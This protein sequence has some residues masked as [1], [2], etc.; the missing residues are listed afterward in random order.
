MN[1]GYIVR[2]IQQ[3]PQFIEAVKELEGGSRR[4]NM[5]GLSGS[6]SAFWAAALAGKGFP[7]VMVCNSGA[8]AREVLE[9]LRSIAGRV[10]Y[11][12]PLQPILYND[13]VHSMEAEWERI[14]TLDALA[15]GGADM[16][17]APAEALFFPVMPS[18]RYK[19]TTLIIRTGEEPGMD[20]V[21]ERLVTA[22]YERGY[23]TEGPGQF[24]VRGGILDIFPVGSPSPCRIE[25]FGDMVDSIRILDADSQ[26]SVDKIDGIRVPPCRELLTEPEERERILRNMDVDLSKTVE[27]LNAFGLG[28]RAEELKEDTAAV[29]AAIATESGTRLLGNYWMYGC[30]TVSL[31]DY[32]DKNCLV[33][34][35]NPVRIKEEAE[36][37]HGDFIDHYND[38]REKG[39][40]LL[41]QQHR[42]LAPVQVEIMLDKIRV[43]GITDILKG[44]GITFG[45]STRGMESFHGKLPLA[46]KEIA[47]LRKDGYL[48]GVLVG[49]DSRLGTLREELVKNDIHPA[50]AEGSTD[51]EFPAGTVVLGRGTVKEGFLF[52]GA[53]LAV[54]SDGDIFGTAKKRFRAVPKAKKQGIEVFTELSPGDYVVHENQGI[55]IYKGIQELKV[56][57]I[58]RDYLKIEYRNGDMLYLPTYQSHLIQKYVGAEG[59]KVRV[60][61]M[62]GREWAKTKASVKRA[63]EGMARELLQLYAAREA[64]AGHAFGGD[65]VWQKQFD[66]LFPFEE[67]PDQIRCIE[68]TKRDMERRRPMDRLLCGDVGYGKTE[69]AMRAAFKAVMDGKQVAMLVPTTILAQQHYNTFRQRMEQFPINIEMM[70]RFRTAGQQQEIL[71]LLKEG[72]IDIL[73]GTHRLL[74]QDVVFKDLGLLVVDE[75]QRFG[76][77]HKEAIKRL[78]ENIDVLTLTAT[79]IPRTLHMSMAGIRDMSVILDPPRDRFPVETFIVE[80]SDR[81]IRDAIQREL[82]RNGQV[83]FVH[84]RVHSI[85]KMARELHALVPG[86]TIGIAHGQMDER[87]LERVMLDFLERRYD[88]L[89]CTTI[90]ENGLDMPNVNTIIVTDSDRLGLSQMYQLKGRVGRSNRIAYAYFTYRKDKV[91]T[92]AAEKRLKAIKE[93]TEFGSGFRIALRDLEIR[94]AGNILGPEQHGHMMAVG[95]DLY[96]KLL[97][98][99]VKE[100]KGLPVEQ[101]VEPQLD[102][103]VDAYISDSYI[104]DEKQKVEIYR[105]IASID[106]FDDYLDVYEELCDRFGEPAGPVTN[107]L[108]LSHIKSMCQRLG[109]QAVSQRDNAIKFEFTQKAPVEPRAL[110]AF[111]NEYAG[112]VKFKASG[113]PS[114]TFRVETG[115]PYK[116][117]LSIKGIIEK[118][119]C[120]NNG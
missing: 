63:I 107:L 119:I 117:L 70:S 75:E 35:D 50:L 103:E 96:C 44:Q 27:R 78:K 39:K 45:F 51:R 28:D 68:E 46:V 9:D 116:L 83:Y 5:S 30:E 62:G 89:L 16:M 77:R 38:R 32:L 85:E 57:N 66:D 19:K 88:I 23:M 37:F 104:P 84:N 8:R 87:A 120:F 31:F 21:L 95:Y 73:I 76:V 69:V 98:Q 118:I 29:K 74:Q 12:P 6:R 26:R 15:S 56:E 61:K 108:L 17:V 115:D 53:K 94:G 92:E 54:F 13:M 105:R 34:L 24:S 60:S 58:K 71:R 99:T 42:I 80:Q 14:S 111:L 97:D 18:D 102:L 79:P 82:G 48:V 7:V 49:S 106:T 25:F 40:V 113:R 47:R 33:V 112:R 109:I 67:T 43:V 91:L 93:F 11:Y 110:V 36:R 86:A 1:F 55:G 100:L 20:R 114:F 65:T 3:S 81:L 59:K 41:R 4:V 64:A 101:R 72:N 10:Y 52:P 2:S 22:G 90:I